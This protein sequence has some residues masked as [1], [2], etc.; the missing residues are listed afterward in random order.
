MR[1]RADESWVMKSCFPC[2]YEFLQSL[3]RS[4]RC[5]WDYGIYFVSKF[6]KQPDVVENLTLGNDSW[7]SWIIRCWNSSTRPIQ[8]RCTWCLPCWTWS[9]DRLVTLSTW[10]LQLPSLPPRREVRAA[11][12]VSHRWWL[13]SESADALAES[14]APVKRSW[15]HTASISHLSELQQFHQTTWNQFSSISYITLRHQHLRM[16]PMRRARTA[17]TGVKFLLKALQRLK[18]FN[19]SK[20][21]AIKMMGYCIFLDAGARLETNWA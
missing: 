6:F 20:L 2:S 9:R 17:T 14:D 19:S 18:P 10:K 8:F 7:E 21:A 15:S 5:T 11:C 16:A 13:K 4:K 1:L 12:G 3:G